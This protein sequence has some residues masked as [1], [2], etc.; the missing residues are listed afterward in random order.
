MRYLSCDECLNICDGTDADS[1]AE[2]RN[3][4]S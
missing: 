2:A 3:L 1:A 4:G